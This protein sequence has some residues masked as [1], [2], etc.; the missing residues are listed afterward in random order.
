MRVCASKIDLNSKPC[1]LPSPPSNS[2]QRSPSTDSGLAVHDETPSSQALQALQAVAGLHPS[3]S[4]PASRLEAAATPAAN[5]YFSPIAASELPAAAATDHEVEKKD[6]H[7]LRI[8]GKFS[9]AETAPFRRPAAPGGPPD[10]W[11]FFLSHRG[12]DTKESLVRPLSYILTQLKIPNFFD[13]SDESM[14][15]GRPADEQMASAAWNCH[16]GVAILSNRF[17]D[18][19]W[20]LK[21]LNTFLLR[22][23]LER[24]KAVLFPVYFAPQLFDT[25]PM[26]YPHIGHLSS[27]I[28]RVD[29]ATQEF[30]V[31]L[32]GRLLAAP[33]IQHLPAVIAARERLQRDPFLIKRLYNRY[34]DGLQEKAKHTKFV[35]KTN[36]AVLERLNQMFQEHRPIYEPLQYSLHPPGATTD[37]ERYDLEP[38]AQALLS[39]HRIVLGQ[40]A[41]GATALD[42]AEW[43]DQHEVVKLLQHMGASTRRDA[44]RL[45]FCTYLISSSCFVE[46]V[47]YRCNTC[48]LVGNLGC[49]AVCKE[50]CHQ[51]HDVSDQL[52]G[53]F[54]C[55]CYASGRCS[56]NLS[57]LMTKPKAHNDNN[58]KPR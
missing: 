10:E 46:Q 16:V 23:H 18:S 20:C 41:F 44:A 26:Y 54:F 30:L 48:N 40:A 51:G 57:A 12:P 3:S 7:A 24:P 8:D 6:D 4:S 34:V 14:R 21:E 50:N 43:S 31:E 19:M 9:E 53:W 58:V 15:P 28:R 36:H 32:P 5:Y 22:N 25:S 11:V 17:A 13:Q 55:D 2:T 37:N 33:D 47:F 39:R 35:D 27:I 29:E 52:K 49:C 56:S 42:L 1:P 38:V 45:Q